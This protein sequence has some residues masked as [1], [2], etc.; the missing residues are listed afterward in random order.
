MSHK[1]LFPVLHSLPSPLQRKKKNF[2]LCCPCT[3]WNMSKLPVVNTLKKTESFP[4]CTPASNHQFQR[5]ML[6]Y[7]IT[8]LRSHSF[9]M[10]LCLSCYFF[11][12]VGKWWVGKW[13]VVTETSLSFSQLWLCSHQ[14][15]SKSN[16]LALYSQC[17]KPDESC[18]LAACLRI[19]AECKLQVGAHHP[20]GTTLQ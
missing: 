15:H 13:G 5:D 6:Q 14:C 8:V 7:P 17:F 20:I 10:A 2:K 9:P 3:Q 18:S 19:E 1:T 11:C 4:T 12:E 16:F